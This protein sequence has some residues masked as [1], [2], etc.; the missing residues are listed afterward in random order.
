LLLGGY[1]MGKIISTSV[2]T[3]ESQKNKLLDESTGYRYVRFL[4]EY[5]WMGWMTKPKSTMI[6]FYQKP[7]TEPVL[8]D[9]AAAKMI[10]GVFL[11]FYPDRK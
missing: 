2:D 11:G 3:A 10:N 7:G 9:D 1:F 4:P 6:Q 5:A 8:E